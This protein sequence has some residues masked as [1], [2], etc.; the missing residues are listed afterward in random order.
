ANPSRLRGRG[1]N[2]SRKTATCEKQLEQLALSQHTAGLPDATRRLK[3]PEN[4]LEAHPF[5]DRDV[6][7]DQCA[8]RDSTA[9]KAARNRGEART[10]RGKALNRA[11]RPALAAVAAARATGPGGWRSLSCPAHRPAPRSSALRCC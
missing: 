2:T 6:I 3:I 4:P 10:R 1:Y 5:T 9:A 11:V 8:Q 7:R